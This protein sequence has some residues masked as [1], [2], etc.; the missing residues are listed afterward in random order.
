MMTRKIFTYL[1]MIPFVWSVVSCT[2][3]DRTMLIIQGALPI[4][5]ETRCVPAVPA[6][7]AGY[8]SRGQVELGVGETSKV[9]TL[10]IHLTYP[11]QEN[12]QQ[13]NL[14]FPNYGS[15]QTANRI[16][17]QEL[18]FL[19]ENQTE[20]EARLESDGAFDWDTQTATTT[21]SGV[22]LALTS[23]QSNGDILA[24][25]EL[26]L[27]NLT[28]PAI[29]GDKETILIH[30]VIRA[31]TLDGDVLESSVLQYPVDICNGCLSNP[32]C[33]TGTVQVGIK[34]TPCHPGQDVPLFTC[35]V[36]GSLE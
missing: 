23:L 12:V 1:C 6:N 19:V 14:A 31:V 35:E 28:V 33:P 13:V 11:F 26:P 32:V 24:I 16:T 7:S 18:E 10:G 5:A 21:P 25:A 8:S 15:V 4:T 34:E 9:Y 17:L 2:G 3:V 30:A 27:Q 22:P 36:P 20:Y 29:A